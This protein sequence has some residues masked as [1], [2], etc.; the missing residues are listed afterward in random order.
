MTTSFQRSDLSGFSR[1]RQQWNSTCSKETSTSVYDTR[2]LC[3]KKLV[4]PGSCLYPILPVV[5]VVARS[6][7]KYYYTMKWSNF[8]GNSYFRA[9]I[10]S[11]IMNYEL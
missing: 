8:A 2:N 5:Y 3:A 6:F 4:P 1:Q 9:E 10:M 11:G 7:Q